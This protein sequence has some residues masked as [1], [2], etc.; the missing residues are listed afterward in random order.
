MSAI[1]IR[2]FGRSTSSTFV[3]KRHPICS[4]APTITV[5]RSICSTVISDFGKFYLSQRKAFTGHHPRTGETMEVPSRRIPIFRA[6]TVLKRA[7]NDG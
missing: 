7:L 1:P 5:P 3:K 4:W 2:S 6:G